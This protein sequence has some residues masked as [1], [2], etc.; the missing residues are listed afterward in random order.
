MIKIKNFVNNFCS[1][2]YSFLI[3]I[4]LK[5]LNIQSKNKK[6]KFYYNHSLGFGDSFTYYISKYDKINKKN[7]YVLDFGHITSLSINFL[8]HKKK[9]KK[10]F[11]YIYS[12]FPHYNIVKLIKN[13]KNFRPTGIKN[14]FD[15]FH[16]KNTK[17]IKKLILTKLNQNQISKELINFLNNKKFLALYF[18]KGNNDIND[19]DASNS[20]QT[21]NI[22]II[23]EI[24]QYLN[25]KKIYL[26]IYGTNNEKVTKEIK[27]ILNNNYKNIFFL[28]DVIKKYT[29][30]DQ[31]YAAH[32]SLGYIGS[33][34]GLVPFFY[35]LRKKQVALNL[36]KSKITRFYSH[37]L[38]YDSKLNYYVYKKIKI[39]N[40]K[41]F[42]VLTEKDIE[43]VSN[44]NI[45]YKIK[46]ATNSEIKKAIKKNFL[47]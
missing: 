34:T 6:I 40:S 41:S 2:L 45:K 33:S 12:F 44:K 10:L 23:K 46:E 18:K 43:Y 3:I 4:E 42:K 31:I 11:F 27:N 25:K 37:D 21:S 38:K 15:T 28:C 16:I 24:A 5:L 29:L 1:K 47:K 14:Y 26:M 7:S 22:K 39:G 30:Q 20:R 17:K 9:V 8:F 36:F 13:S 19:L 32:K 35:F